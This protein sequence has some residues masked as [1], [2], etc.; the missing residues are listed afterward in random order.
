MIILD[1]NVIS[2]LMR[3]EPAEAVVRWVNRQ[4]SSS[5]YATSITQ[6]EILH[7]IQLLPK[8]KR[9]DVIAAA[10]EEMFERDFGGRILVFGTDAAKAYA[11]IGAARRRT[12]R[13][14]SAFDA[15]IAA[16]ARTH[17]ANIATRNVG[18]FAGC[19]V[20]VVDPWNI[21]S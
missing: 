10:A 3:R 14:I 20:P 21:K 4:A 5:L 12:G 6:A 13:P 9:R 19:G 7:G 15:Q 1:T 11:I 8:G 18:D 16:I 17:G 2:E